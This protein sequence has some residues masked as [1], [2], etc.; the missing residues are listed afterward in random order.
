VVE[1][2][3]FISFIS[4]GFFFFVSLLFCL[5]DTLNLEVVTMGIL[6]KLELK[7][8]GP[9]PLP[10]KVTD[11]GLA[12]YG[13][14]EMN[15]A[16]LEMPGLMKL[17]SEFKYSLPFKNCRISG[18]SNLTIEAA[19]MLETLK[20]LGADVRWCSC[21]IFSTQDHA[22]AALVQNNVASIFAWKDEVLD[23]PHIFL[24]LLYNMY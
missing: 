23:I 21:N 24:L 20:L 19:V 11:L 15:N 1:Y 12:N 22:T 13:A 14:D 7:Q 17:R 6:E 10:H 2:V 9:A 18:T 4:L 5:P 3:S 8:S 16:R